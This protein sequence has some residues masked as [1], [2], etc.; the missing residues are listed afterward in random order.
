MARREG[1]GVVPMKKPRKGSRIVVVVQN[2]VAARPVRV[3]RTIVVRAGARTLTPKIGP[4]AVQ[5][6]EENAT[7]ARGWTTPEALALF[8]AVALENCVAT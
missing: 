2:P 3:W 4:L 5:L 1:A 7:W 8:A 6:A